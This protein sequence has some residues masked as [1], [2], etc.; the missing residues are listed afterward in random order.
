MRHGIACAMKVGLSLKLHVSI[1]SAMKATLV[2]CWNHAMLSVPCYCCASIAIPALNFI[3]MAAHSNN[4]HSIRQNGVVVL[5]HVLNTGAAALTLYNP[6]WNLT[7][8]R[9]AAQLCFRTVHRMLAWRH[10]FKHEDKH[11]IQNQG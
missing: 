2:P 8:Q 5:C 6:V 10:C 9:S 11:G 4:A 7:K 3:S 1:I